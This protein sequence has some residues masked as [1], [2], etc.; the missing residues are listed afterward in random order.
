MF[1]AEQYWFAHPR[2]KNGKSGGQVD[3]RR[4]S[5][6]GLHVKALWRPGE[7]VEGLDLIR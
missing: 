6:S 2:I 7:T 5:P 4:V 3:R 1:L